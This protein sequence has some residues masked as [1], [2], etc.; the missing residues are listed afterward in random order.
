MQ[1]PAKVVGKGAANKLAK[2]VDGARKRAAGC[3]RCVLASFVAG[4]VARS[5]RREE[6][7]GL[8][9]RLERRGQVQAHGDS[10]RGKLGGVLAFAGRDAAV[11][12]AGRCEDRRHAHRG[13]VGTLTDPGASR[14]ARCP[15]VA[16][17]ASMDHLYAVTGV[18]LLETPPCRRR[19]ASPGRCASRSS[20]TRASGDV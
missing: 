11:S 2:Q 9:D 12:R 5:G 10:G 18:T 1:A 7:S 14:R 19:A 15:A 3:G 4:F 6:R 13:A 8:R 17:R 16:A 20:G